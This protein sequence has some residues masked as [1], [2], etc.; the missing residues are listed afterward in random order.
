[1][2][3]CDQCAKCPCAVYPQLV[4]PLNTVQRDI[5]VIGE[6]VTPGEARKGTVMTGT[7]ADILKQTMIKVGM[8]ADPD[9]VFYTTAVACAVPRKKGKPFPKEPMI[10][11]RDRLLREISQV[12][13]KFII[14]LGK[15]AF[16]TLTNEFNTKITEEYGRAR[17]YSYCG[18]AQ[19]IPVMH[20]ALI[21]RAPGDYKPFL[22]SMFLIS[23]LYK[24][25]SAH[26]TGETRW[27]VL[28]TEAKIDQALRF[29]P[30]FKRVSADIET[31][32]LD[33]RTAEFCVMGIG[34]AKNKVLVIPRELRHRVKEFF[35]LPNI[36]WTWQGGKY[37]KKVLWRRK[38]GTVSIDADTMYM[39]YVLDETSSHDLGS[40]TKN[41]LQAAEYKYKMNQ[42]WKA[43]TLESYPQ[44]F[45][46]LC[47]RVA[48]DCDYTYQLEDVLMAEID[49]PENAC[50]KKLYHELL[51]PASN[52]LSRVEQNGMLVDKDYLDEMNKK[53]DIL[54]AKILDEVQE[55]AA[56]YW[57]RELY[58]EQT[59][60]KSGPIKFNPGSPKQMAWMVFDRLKL[61][62]R[63][64]KGRST[65][66]DILKSIDTDLPLIKKVLEYRSTQKEQSTYIEG[67]LKARDVDGRVR[68]T[69]SLHIAATGRLTSKEPNVQNIT[70]ANGVGNVRRAHI[71]KKGFIL[72]EIDYSGAELRWL[73]F[74]SR[75]PVM[76][77][78]FLTGRNLHTE[79]ATALYGP[80]FNKVQK[81]RAKA[82]NFG[83][84][85][86]REDKSFMDEF[87][88]TKEEAHEMRMGWLNKYHGCRDYLQWCADQVK[89]GHYLETPWGRRRRFGLVTPESLHNLQ[90]EA[91][92]FPIQSS[93][94]DLLLHC[95][96]QVEKPLLKNFN[97][98]ITDLI[99]DSMLLE[100]P[101]DAE[102][103]KAVGE[104]VSSVMVQAPI[105]L[106]NCDVP[107][108][109]DYEIGADWGNLVGFDTKSKQVFW[110][111]KATDS[112][113]YMNYDE[114]LAGA[115][116]Y[117]IYETEWYKSLA[118]L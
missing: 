117:D 82:T 24:G 12:K 67:T 114:W 53:Y 105:D 68:S 26:D 4:R 37:D 112:D 17:T 60:A 23:N 103:I 55:A 118:T 22:A 21:V 3:A 38:L 85:Y 56:P 115:Y 95:A 2:S 100:M 89:L 19:V 54:I 78:V 64:K 42:N 88:M 91:R 18:E 35:E 66:K 41:F 99:H 25:G 73:A 87:N 29:L 97:T 44:F 86:G 106:F 45:E 62:P 104:Y 58:M 31:T 52:F 1:M 20:P 113:V 111:D 80:H 81:L 33:Y 59:G 76:M 110:E 28:D 72:G 5:M 92:N 27:Q 69:F 46:A 51:I 102:T 32:G 34:F 10:Y 116:H 70:S 84:P 93:S 108:K 98:R 39:H 49:K 101:N 61:K 30:Q 109:T 48:V 40:L 11:C 8:P 13:P 57:D 7:G 74:L 96:M 77:D 90:N 75:C 50:L 63:L 107:F 6:V 15:T 47:E 79:T 14:V 83:I 16:Q 65:D 71:P 9:H 94:S 43:V 36:R